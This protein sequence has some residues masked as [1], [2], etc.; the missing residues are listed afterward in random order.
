MFCCISYTVGPMYMCHRGINVHVTH[1][2]VIQYRFRV[3]CMWNLAKT[4]HTV[5]LH[6]QLYLHLEHVWVYM[7][8][9]ITKCLHSWLFLLIKLDWSLYNHK[10]YGHLDSASAIKLSLPLMCFMTRSNSWRVRLQRNNRWFWLFILCTKANG[11]WSLYTI[12]GLG[13]A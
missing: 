1:K 11:L 12:I 13:A 8:V 4:V 9:Y 3:T 10:T 5:Y 2:C 7:Y 6:V